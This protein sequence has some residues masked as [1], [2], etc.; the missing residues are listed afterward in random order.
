MASKFKAY[1][2]LVSVFVGLSVIQR[3]GFF[4]GWKVWLGIAVSVPLGLWAMNAVMEYDRPRSRDEA[5]NG[6]S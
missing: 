2:A 6:R 4:D 3:L 1:F 5:D